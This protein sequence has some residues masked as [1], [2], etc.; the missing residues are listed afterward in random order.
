MNRSPHAPATTSLAILLPALLCAASTLAAPAPPAYRAP[1][2]FTVTSS[3]AAP[4]P[5]AW[6]CTT[7]R[8]P[9]ENIMS[10]CEYEGFNFRTRFFAADDGVD[11]IPASPA[12]ATGWDTRREGFY[13]GAT[14]RVYRVINGKLV[15]VR[16]AAVAK[17]RA[18]GWMPARGD[19]IV[20]PGTTSFRWSFE[21]YNSPVAPYY[22]SV[23]AVAKD[24]T[25]SA[26]S[27]AI[28]LKRPEKCEAKAVNEGLLAF[29]WPKQGPGSAR[30]SAPASPANFRVAGE[31]DGVFTFEWDRS[32]SADI[33]GYLVLISDYPP[34]KH[35]GY[36]YDLANKASGPDQQIKKG[37]MVFLDMHRLDFSR[38]KLA[39]NRVWGDWASAGL[40]EVFPGQLGESEGHTWSLVPHPEPIPAEFDAAQRGRTC[41]KIDMKD[42]E[43]ISLK[44]YNHSGPAQNWYPVLKVGRT[45]VLEFWARQSGMADPTVKFGFTGVYDKEIKQDFTISGDWKKYTYEFSPQTEWP[46]ENTSVG[47]MKLTFA[48]P[49]TLWLDGVRVYPKDAGYMRLPVADIEALRDSGMEFY[50]TH[51]FVKSG[52][53]YFLDDL[54]SAPGVTAYR[55]NLINDAAQFTLPMVLGYLKEARINPWLQVEMSFSEPEWLGLVEY[56][57]APYDPAKDTP[58][59]KPWAYKRYSTGQQKPWTDEFGKFIFE[60]SNET[61]NP[62]FQPWTFSWMNM[63]DAA[64]GRI[65]THGE[66]AGLMTGYVLEQMKKSPYWPALGPKMETA[67]GGWLIEL[68]DN[69]YGQ[70]AC[71]V[72]PDIKHALV[73]NYNGGWDEGAGA[74]AADDKGYRLALTVVPQ[75]IHG[76]N[77]ELAQTRDR[78]AAAGTKFKVGTYEAG[79]GYSLPNTISHEQEE[80]ESQVQKSQAAGTATLDCFLDAAQQGFGLQ[81]YFT[82]SRG[83]HYWASHAE[84]RRGGQAYPSWSALTLY[85]NH[86]RGDFLVVQPSSIPSDKLEKTKTRA[87]A[88][89]APLTGV[90]A[91]RDGDRYTVFVLSRKLDNFPYAGD[92]GYTPVTLH[93]PFQSAKKITLYKMS[94]DPRA[95]NLDAENVKIQTE[96]IPAKEFSPT[97]VLDKA[98]GA[99]A[100]GLPPAAT[101]LYVFEG[102]TTAKLPENPAGTLK[103]AFGQPETTGQ[104][105]VQFLALF[106][107]AMNDLAPEKVKVTGTAGGVVHVEKPVDLGGTGFLITV[108]DMDTS[109]DVGVEIPAGAVTDAK[110]APNAPVS[111][112]VLKYRTRPPED[113]IAVS[114][115]FDA[116]DGKTL[117]TGGGA[118][119]TGWKGTWSLHNVKVDPAEPP[120][121]FALSTAQPLSYT[122]L[123][124]T[125]G[126]LEAGVAFKSFWRWLDVENAL[127]YAK[128]ATKDAK[129]PAQ[130]GLSGTTV[131]ISFLVRQD[132]PENDEALLS[133]NADEF[134]K[135]E[136]PAVRFGHPA[137][138]NKT[139]GPAWGID[140][141]NP[142]TKAWTNIPTSIPVESGKTVLLVARIT[143]GRKDS[144]AL[145]VDPPLTGKPPAKP[146][147]EYTSE[148]GQKLYFRNVV[149]WGGKPGNASFDEIR[150][151]DSF[152]AVTPAKP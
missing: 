75:Y 61:W 100:R 98:R 132:S 124:S 79:P 80:A 22:F 50:R 118:G 135:G 1:A 56:L 131:W 58:E 85:N 121:G 106:D 149:L 123:A 128:R 107:R 77:G 141:W 38:N 39:A 113:K 76:K 23:V 7:E 92:D 102:T 16:T 12:D 95:A 8:P 97:F 71:K 136:F 144:V 115:S 72:C 67:V 66:L 87:E 83:R 10:G 148:N 20:P 129:Q 45:Y 116:P 28:E 140:V 34:D 26:P 94:G 55:G 112:P 63:P 62:L 152:K 60:V 143:Y 29:Q 99:D 145:Y 30:G 64:T 69:G 125:P 19:K 119:G 48:G 9:V 127:G 84:E 59:T 88:A 108:A 86:G 41:L 130:V 117:W 17:H 33:A 13:D 134:Y 90:Y 6:T 49:G 114:E 81:N 53:S 91:T 43:K 15:N 3:V 126:Y 147:A 120:E 109:G 73:A 137:W 103:P 14:A 54:T 74:A 40:P 146:D 36:G 2:E 133:L 57:A 46:A 68:G 27:N 142:D 4:N 52:K 78:L 42:S 35:V 11:T 24:G 21:H 5:G 138:L 122:G 151:G 31:K 96:E 104:P 111:S 139:G 105:S 37:D 150:I 110:A 44:E 65:Y 93:L 18:S 70:A 82:F 47:Q 25:W 101:F 89:A 32:G 51:M